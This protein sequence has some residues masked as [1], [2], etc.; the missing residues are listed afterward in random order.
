M[1]DLQ[2]HPRTS[3][4]VI[5][6]HGRS[7]GIIE[8]TR[9]LRELTP[10][11]AAKPAHL[12]SVRPAV[13]AYLPTGFSDW[14]GKGIYRGQNPPEGALFTVW[15]KEFAGEEI[16]IAITNAAGQP[17]ANLKAPGVMGLT[18]LNWDLRPSEEILAKYGGDDGKKFLPDGDYTAELSYG[19]TKM[20]QTFHVDIAEGITTR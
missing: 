10:E 8:D 12:F 6:T 15:I 18:R 4:L 9:P 14:N 17:V 5:A 20:K 7:I 1:D 19:K 16:K 11:I 2:I 3:D 13:G